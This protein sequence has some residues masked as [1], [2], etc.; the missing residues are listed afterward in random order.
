MLRKMTKF[1]EMRNVNNILMLKVRKIIYHRSPIQKHLFRHYPLTRG[2]G[3]LYLNRRP[4]IDSTYERLLCCQ[5]IAS[6]VGISL[7]ESKTDDRFYL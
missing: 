6:R 7:S 4:M 3:F 1:N 5:D 2:L